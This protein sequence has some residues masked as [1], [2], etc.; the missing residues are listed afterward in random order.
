MEVALIVVLLIFRENPFSGDFIFSAVY[1]V[2]ALFA[3]RMETNDF[4]KAV[5]FI[6]YF[7]KVNM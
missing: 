6:I 7:K 3:L 5:S 4:V 1:G 2:V